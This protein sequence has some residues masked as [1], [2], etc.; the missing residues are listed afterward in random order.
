MS[1]GR[2]RVKI[3]GLTRVEDA[4]VAVD[5][6]ADAIGFILWP[7]SPRFVELAAA[8]AIARAVPPCVARVGVFV[9][10]SSDEVRR[11]A[12]VIG[13]HA[14]QLHGDEDVADFMNVGRPV[15]KAV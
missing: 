15:M 8:A 2:L 9:N 3:C 4:R 5:L 10:A 1:V 11:T 7:K 13:L 12:D 6:G 14:V